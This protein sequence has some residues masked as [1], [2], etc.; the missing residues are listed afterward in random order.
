MNMDLL[1]RRLER[2]DFTALEAVDGGSGVALC[3]ACPSSTAGPP[4]A[5]SAPIRP[6]IAL[7]ARALSSDRDRAFEAGCDEQDTKPVELTRLLAKI[8]AQLGG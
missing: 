7:T 6:L 8:E 2:R 4:P 3:R 5:P 1:S